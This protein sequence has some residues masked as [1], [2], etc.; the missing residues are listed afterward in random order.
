MTDASASEA[1]PG[2]RKK[3]SLAMQVISWLGAIGCFYLVY[4]RIAA[5]AGR[6]RT[7]RNAGWGLDDAPVSGQW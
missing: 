2:G 3:P 4:G 1:A 7:V 5:A 6:R